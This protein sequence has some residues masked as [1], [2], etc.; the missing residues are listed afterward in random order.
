MSDE[1]WGLNRER[2]PVSEP[3]GKTPR[4]LARMGFRPAISSGPLRLTGIQNRCHG[5]VR[6]DWKAIRAPSGVHTGR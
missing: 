5:P 4:R 3:P 6:F 2:R 1:V